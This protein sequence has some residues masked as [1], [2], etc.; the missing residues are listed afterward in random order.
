MDSIELIYDRNDCAVWYDS[1]PAPDAIAEYTKKVEFLKGLIETEKLVSWE[2]NPDIFH[3][4][5]MLKFLFLQRPVI[6]Y[7]G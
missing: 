6:C 7:I 1:K 5:I 3:N 2:N 4:I